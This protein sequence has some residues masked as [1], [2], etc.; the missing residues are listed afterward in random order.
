MPSAL[1]V[2]VRV[3]PL[4]CSHCR[5]GVVTRNATTVAVQGR[6]REVPAS[7]GGEPVVFTSGGGRAGG[8]VAQGQHSTPHCGAGSPS[9]GRLIGWVGFSTMATNSEVDVKVEEQAGCLPLSEGTSTR[10]TVT[11]WN[12]GGLNWPPAPC[13][14]LVPSLVSVLL[15]LK[16]MLMGVST[17]V[18]L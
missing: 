13:V 7:R 11:P 16:L 2:L 9:I 6:V 4:G 3:E 18:L 1:G 12:T 15:K 5:V 17:S 10:Y 14:T 8:G